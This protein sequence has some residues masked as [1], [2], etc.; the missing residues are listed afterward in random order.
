VSDQPAHHNQKHG[1]YSVK[2]Q[3]LLRQTKSLNALV[4][5]HAILP[6]VAVVRQEDQLKRM[7]ETIIRLFK[8]PDVAKM[9][10][11]ISGLA[12]LQRAH[13]D[14]VRCQRETIEWIKKMSP[15]EG[16][17]GTS[18]PPPIETEVEVRGQPDEA[19]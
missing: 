12:T 9:P 14:T 2:V 8:D 17:E 3:E 4:A 18:G 7:H 6:H 15:P 13:N 19:S 1:L 5:N 10:G 11:G 16:G